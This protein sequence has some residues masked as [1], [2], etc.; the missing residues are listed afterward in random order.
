VSSNDSFP[1]ANERV[2]CSS[3]SIDS[4]GCPTESA[5]MEIGWKE[6]TKA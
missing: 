1:A 4:R 5:S 6:L 3:I 2:P